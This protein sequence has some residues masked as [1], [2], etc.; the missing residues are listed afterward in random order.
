MIRQRVRMP[1]RRALGLAPPLKST[2]QTLCRTPVLYR[3]ACPTSTCVL[4]MQPPQF[5]APVVHMHHTNTN[6]A[7]STSILRWSSSIFFHSRRS[8]RRLLFRTTSMRLCANWHSSLLLH[9]SPLLHIRVLN[10]ICCCGMCNIFFCVYNTPHFVVVVHLIEGATQINNL[11]C[12][13]ATKQ[14]LSQQPTSP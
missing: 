12:H 5:L 2:F 7:S 6:P 11:R 8:A 13:A 3:Q 10:S 1:G 4:F 9:R 14:I